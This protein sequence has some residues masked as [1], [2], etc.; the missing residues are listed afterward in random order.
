[1]TPRGVR[2]VGLVAGA[3][4]GALL[5]ALFFARRGGDVGHLPVLLAAFA[6]ALGRGPMLDAAAW[7]PALG[8]AAL[9]GAI[10]VAWLGVGD[11]VARACPAPR[12]PGARAL[13]VAG[14][15]LV[16]AGVWSVAWFLLGAAH[17]FRTPVAVVALGGGVGLGAL[18]WR[19]RERGVAPRARWPAVARTGVALIVLVQ[20]LALI[21][22][23]A[24]PTANDTLLYHLALPKAYVAAGGAVDVPYNIASF[25][26]L[27]VEMLGVWVLLLGP[28]AG[29]RVA[30]AAAGATV[31]A[32]A[33]LLAAVTFGWARERGA[34]LAWASLG[35]LSVAAIPTA[36]DVA[37]GGYVDLALAAYTAL[38]V[39]S[40]G[41]WWTTLDRAWL[42]PLAL[43]IGFA[44]SIKVTVAF[45]V[46]AAA[47]VVLVRALGAASA[48]GTRSAAP[49]L[50]ALA[51]GVAIASPWYLRNWVRTGNPVFPFMLG[52]LGGQAPGWDL[53]RSQLYESLFSLYGNALTPLDYVLS[54]V[55]LAIAAQPEEPVYY[56]GVLGVSFLFATG[57]AAWAWLRRRLDGELVLALLLS[58]GLF[59]FWL[60]SSQQL[61]YLLPAAPA[62]AVALAVAGEAAAAALG[63]TPGRAFRWVVLAVAGAGVP[64][65]LAWFLFVDPLRVVLGGETRVHYLARRLDYYPYYEQVNRELPPSARVWLIH[66]RRDTYYLERPYFSDFIFED[67][68]LRE[69]VRAA[70]DVGALDARVRAAGITHI[71]MR[72][73][74]L[75]DPRRSAIVDGTRSPADNAAKLMLFATFLREGTVMLRGDAKYW[76][77]ALRPRPAP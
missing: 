3:G 49:A 20:M 19:R 74:L 29:A 12:E 14:R 55:R 6:A 43:A 42:A 37:G 63:P 28:V 50:A 61:R 44:L 52:L 58:A 46:L 33:P 70:P 66:M 56:D 39:R 27:G 35:A 17:L 68:T 9:A 5:L 62:L 16:G 38:A 75:L 11:L 21:A 47:L 54:P 13:D 65:V 34:G 25:Y 26:P 53:T 1:M 71:L 45:L 8:G 40:L 23:L 64:V 48:G 51:L 4:S 76:L 60:F 10:V 22:A 41:R 32:F 69:W 7:G 77:L 73:D 30:E 31:F 36:Y 57:L 24:P 67:W 59:V 72:H 18:A 2:G 15:V